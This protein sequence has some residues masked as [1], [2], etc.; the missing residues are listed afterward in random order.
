VLE[1]ENESEDNEWLEKKRTVAFF[2]LRNLRA[3]RGETPTSM[4][5]IEK[6]DPKTLLVNGAATASGVS[7]GE[8]ELQ[9][10]QTL[11]ETVE[12]RMSPQERTRTQVILDE[13]SDFIQEESDYLLE[14]II[15]LFII[16]IKTT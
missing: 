4:L 9:A 16:M 12:L 10:A 15:K 11:P 7:S 14:K 1:N 8:L 6:I 5:R 13:M 3:V 2:R